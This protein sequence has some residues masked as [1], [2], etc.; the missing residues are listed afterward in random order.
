MS[1]YR[2]IGLIE[3]NTRLLMKTLSNKTGFV[4]LNR[5]IRLALEFEHPLTTN[6]MLSRIRRDKNPCVVFKKGIKLCRHGLAPFRMT[7]SVSITGW[8][9]RRRAGES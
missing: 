2:T 4:P 9:S 1:D 5:T 6:N 3:V 7:S 8:F